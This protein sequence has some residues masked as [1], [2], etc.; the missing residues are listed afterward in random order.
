MCEYIKKYKINRGPPL[1][2]LYLFSYRIYTYNKNFL[3]KLF[4]S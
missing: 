2:D 4:D 1:E 3:Q